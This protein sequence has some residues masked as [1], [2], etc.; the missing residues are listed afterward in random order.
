MLHPMRDESALG[1]EVQAGGVL[2][3]CSNEGRVA[4]CCL[5]G[6]P[7]EMLLP[8]RARPVLWS[9]L[10]VLSALTKMLSHTS[11]GGGAWCQTRSQR[12]SKELTGICRTR[13]AR[14]DTESGGRW[15]DNVAWGSNGPL[16]GRKPCR[17]CTGAVESVARLP[18]AKPE[19]RR[20]LC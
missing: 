19:A 9:D 7:E 11:V 10:R 4:T 16:S 15:T 1:R 8:F 13:I 2:V 17:A 14:P 5:A 3:D 20:H 6:W 12:W 18:G